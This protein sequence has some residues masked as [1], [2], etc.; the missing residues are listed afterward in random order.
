MALRDDL[1]KERSEKDKKEANDAKKRKDYL[2]LEKKNKTLSARSDKEAKKARDRARV[3]SVKEGLKKGKVPPEWETIYANAISKIERTL[4]D[5]VTEFSFKDEVDKEYYEGKKAE[6]GMMN[7]YLTKRLRKEGF[8]HATFLLRHTSEKYQTDEDRKR[9][10]SEQEHLDNAAQEDYDRKYYEW[11][12]DETGRVSEPTLKLKTAKWRATGV[13]HHYFWEIK[14]GLYHLGA[15]KA[16]DSKFDDKNTAVTSTITGFGALVGGVIAFLFKLYNIDIFPSLEFF[17]TI[18]TFA[19]FIGL[20]AGAGFLIALF[21][22]TIRKEIRRIVIHKSS[23]KTLAISLSV[24]LAAVLALGG[25]SAAFYFMF[26]FETV[27]MDG[28]TYVKDYNV[29]NIKSLDPKAEEITIR[30]S[31]RFMDVDARYWPE[32]LFDKCDNLKRLYL[33]ENFMRCDLS[34]V[35][36][37]LEYLSIGKLDTMT[38]FSSYC[39]DSDGG[40]ASSSNGSSNADKKPLEVHVRNVDVLPNSAFSGDRIIRKF[41][42]EKTIKEIG[43]SAF[44]GTRLSTLEG[45][46]SAT[47]I[48]EAAFMGCNQLESVTLPDGLKIIEAETFS[49]CRSLKTVNIPDSVTE[50]RAK[51]FCDCDVLETIDLPDSITTIGARVFGDCDSFKSIRLPDGIKTIEASTFY[52][53]VALTDISI[54]DSVTKIGSNAFQRC[55]FLKDASFLPDSLEY[56]GSFAFSGSGLETLKLP[57]NVKYIREGAF[58]E[59]LSLETAI[60]PHATELHDGKIFSKCANLRYVSFGDSVTRIHEETISTDQPLTITIGKNLEYVDTNAIIASKG[61]ER[62]NF[63]GTESEWKALRNRIYSSTWDRWNDIVVLN[64]TG[65]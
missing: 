7:K 8:K 16:D 35:F 1:V 58:Y 9:R 12:Y 46:E 60:I 18:L 11:L 13:L 61:L 39:Y 53:C 23:G 49:G 43:N 26:P 41:T 36:D 52:D 24:A 63:R 27:T 37:T 33:P 19:L 40:S 50:I 64:Y 38:T 51:A 10:N 59:C 30:G 62:V 3:K 34:P 4:K 2:A 56:I 44:K 57:D 14:G 47:V 6:L 65:E 5:D 20:G 54:P 15:S 31:V 32:G 48:G 25:G 55:G 17:G 21:I 28:V 45:L 29:Y 42:F 22:N